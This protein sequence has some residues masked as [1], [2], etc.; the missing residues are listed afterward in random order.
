VTF[1]RCAGLFAIAAAF[2]LG[3][4]AA[5]AL[6]ARH[7]PGVSI[8]FA[9]PVVVVTAWGRY[10]SACF[11]VLAATVACA[12]LA[13]L[14]VVRNAGAPPGAGRLGAAR[15][16][17][18]R[19]AAIAL[20]AA[21]A[22]AA[23]LAWP[24]VFSSDVYAYAAYGWLAGHGGDP[25][26]PVPRAAHGAFVE[27]ARFQW[28]GSFPACVYGPAFVTLARAAVAATGGADVGGALVLLRLLA[29]GAFVGSIF[30]LDGCLRGM[31]A[32][33]R[34]RT[35]AAFA[36]NPVAIWSVAEGHNDAFVLLGALL[37]F[38]LVRRGTL[39][40]GAF[41]IGLTPLL[42]ATGAALA[43]GFALDAFAFAPQRARRLIAPLAAGLAVAVALAVPPVLPVLR[44]IRTIGHYAPS[45]SAQSFAGVVPAAVC[46]LA[47]AVYGVIRLGAR[48]RDGH[49]WLGI[50]AWLALPNPY[51]WY[52]LWFLPAVAAA[53]GGAAA[54]GLYG[55]TISSVVRYLPDASGHID[56]SGL[57][58]AA[59]VGL[60]PLLLAFA[61][62]A[63][64]LPLRKT[65]PQI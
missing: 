3:A 8:D 24:F 37:G 44:A 26:L 29:C 38:R 19:V 17:P 25:Y 9:Q 6:A 63:R 59:A 54:A 7:A 56:P 60:L 48:E 52:A 28:G 27:A 12:A 4:G 40:A 35:V 61:A 42:K 30:V 53:G 1:R 43:I 49:A 36:L 14:I 41:V 62:F 39:A 47:A 58:L 33:R 5:Q 16:A 10:G 22:L 11:A 31:D 50:A 51:P 64:P 65:N 21:A 18:P 2:A 32:V 46:A 20:A 57:R 13:L 55:V 34:F 15:P 23:A 45:V